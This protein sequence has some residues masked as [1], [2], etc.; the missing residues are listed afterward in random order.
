VEVGYLQVF[1]FHTK[2][3]SAYVSPKKEKPQNAKTDAKKRRIERT[4]M[5]QQVGKETKN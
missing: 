4:K 5:M 2:I 3:T 1:G